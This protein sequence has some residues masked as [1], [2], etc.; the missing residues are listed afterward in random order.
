MQVTIN[1]RAYDGVVSGLLQMDF[2]P[3]YPQGET[4]LEPPMQILVSGDPP[5]P[6][7]SASAAP[8]ASS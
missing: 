6:P 1:G 7:A 2:G 3:G 4:T 5:V 8:E